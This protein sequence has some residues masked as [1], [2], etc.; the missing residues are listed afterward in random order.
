ML[1]LTRVVLHAGHIDFTWEMNV[2]VKASRIGYAGTCSIT[3][4]PFPA[5]LATK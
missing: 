3:A 4:S 1:T 2:F 5:E